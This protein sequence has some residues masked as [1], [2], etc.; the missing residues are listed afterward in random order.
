[1]HKITDSL[2]AVCNVILFLLRAHI[3]LQS[4]FRSDGNFRF[5]NN[6]AIKGK[7]YCE[8]YLACCDFAQ[9]PGDMNVAL[10]FP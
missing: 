5:P 1:M 8:I 6:R 2:S 3:E 7:L 9:T 4:A 10:Q